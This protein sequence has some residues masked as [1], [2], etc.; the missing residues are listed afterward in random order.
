MKMETTDWTKKS[1]IIRSISFFFFGNTLP[2]VG[3]NQASV[4]APQMF[5]ASASFISTIFT[6]VDDIACSYAYPVFSFHFQMFLV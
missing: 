5:S 6:V 2:F 1:I 4:L 3:L